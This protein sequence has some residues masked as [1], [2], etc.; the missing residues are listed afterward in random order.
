MPVKDV[1]HGATILSP[2]TSI[3]DVSEMMR[4]KNIG[5]VLVKMSH[6]SY[7]IVTERDIVT[8]VVA[9]KLEPSETKAS[10]AM[11]ELKYT[12]DAQASLDDASKIFNE[13]P[14]RRLPVTE[15]GE[16]I[17]MI[18]TRDVARR[19]SYDYRFSKKTYGTTGRFR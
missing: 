2:E 4:E 5:S 7:G 3:L 9:R 14:I 6:A 16:I 11:T 19:K 13:Q 12:I 18:T 15:N 10:D 17:G 1:M 8:K